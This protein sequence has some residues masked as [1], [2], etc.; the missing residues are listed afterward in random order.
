MIIL[1]EDEPG[2][3]AES[4]SEPSS[5]AEFAPSEQEQSISRI[6]D[7]LLEPEKETEESTDS[8]SPKSK[9]RSS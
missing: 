9:A 8:S 1:A 4:V 5:E 6:D 7:T 3:E 2:G